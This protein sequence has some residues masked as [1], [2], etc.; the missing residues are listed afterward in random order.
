MRF[1]GEQ[2]A[3]P[4]SGSDNLK[5]TPSRIVTPSSNSPYKLVNRTTSK[6]TILALNV[7]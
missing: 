4:V 2:G 1:A 5:F 3:V 6:L 7:K